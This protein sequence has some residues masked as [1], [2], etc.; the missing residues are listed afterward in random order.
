MWTLDDSFLKDYEL[1]D[2]L[3]L[4]F[5]VL[6]LTAFFATLVYSVRYV[7]NKNKLRFLSIAGKVRSLLYFGYLFTVL[8]SLVYYFSRVFN[9][10]VKTVIFILRLF[11]ILS[12][13]AFLSSYC[14]YLMYLHSEAAHAAIVLF[15]VLCYH[16]SVFKS[17]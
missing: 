17:R 10:R 6:Y 4:L 14:I 16:V 5:I 7:F 11:V 2:G 9:T 8:F 12:G 15:Y 1:I 13:L 3:Q